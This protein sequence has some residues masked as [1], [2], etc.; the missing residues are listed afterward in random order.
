MQHDSVL[1]A[2]GLLFDGQSEPVSAHGVLISEGR[3]RRIAPAA[4]FEG[5]EGQRI[6]TTGQT[7][8]PGLIDCHVHMTFGAEPNMADAVSR[9]GLADLV[10]KTLEN[11]QAT[12]RGGITSVRDCG[13]REFV[14][15]VIRDAINEGRHQ[16]PSLRCAGRLICITGGHGRWIG[17]EADGVDEVRK[18]VRETIRGGADCVKMMATGGVTTPNV[19]PLV[20]HFTPEEIAAGIEEAHRFGL[21]VASHAQGADGIRN[22]VEG[23][24]DSIEHG[25]EL[26]EPLIETMIAKGVY[27][28]PTLSASAMLLSQA[29]D[30]LPQFMF[31]KASRFREMHESSFKGF[32]AAGGRIA[33]GTDAGTPFNFHGDNAQELAHMVRLGM[34][35]LEALRAGTSVAA[36]LLDLPGHG[37]V[38]EGK[39]AD[40]LLVDGNPIEDVSAAADR[41][42]HVMVMKNGRPVNIVGS[43][44]ASKE[45]ERCIAAA[46]ARGGSLGALPDV[47]A[48]CCWGEGGHGDQV[49]SRL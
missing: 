23:G 26:T 37:S 28:V 47:P 17:R 48:G 43:A 1:F 29:R 19:D 20:A 39:C 33:M 31:D 27:L 41:R 44:P 24:V 25:F 38:A 12:L 35:P 6:D 42:N 21:R 34:S 4:E 49:R 8:M 10:L 9:I 14:E 32:V 5:Y 30:L 15:I 22:A 40:L 3:I 46:K 2:G 36:D 7:L 13:G 45:I 11:A 18:A 16:G